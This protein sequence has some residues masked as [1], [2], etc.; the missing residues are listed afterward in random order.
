MPS[1][2]RGSNQNK[3]RNTRPFQQAR[4][5]TAPRQ[6]VRFVQPS[7]QVV[8]VQEKKKPPTKP[9]FLN[10]DLL[11]TDARRTMNSANLA[12]LISKITLVLKQGYGQVVKTENGYNVDV[13]VHA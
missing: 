3:G 9:T 11:P 10:P 1:R 6:R 5:N 7:P 2:A 12:S 8:Y 4:R 13:G